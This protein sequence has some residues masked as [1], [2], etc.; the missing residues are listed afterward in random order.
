MSSHA[1]GREKIGFTLYLVNILVN[2]IVWILDD[3]FLG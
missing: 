3:D 2:F 1:V